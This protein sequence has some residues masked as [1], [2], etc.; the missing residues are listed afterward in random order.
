MKVQMIR[1]MQLGFAAVLTVPLVI[2]VVFGRR[3]H[4]N[5]YITKPMDLDWFLKVVRSI[6]NFWLPMVKLP[7][8]TR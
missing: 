7:G 2:D 1:K 8:D 3:L 4:A 5:C 6:D